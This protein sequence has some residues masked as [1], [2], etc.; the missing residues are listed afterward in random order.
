MLT[1]VTIPPT[2]RLIR[3]KQLFEN[4]KWI[5]T[6]NNLPAESIGRKWI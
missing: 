3:V 2:V 1:T 6:Y 4:R 5:G